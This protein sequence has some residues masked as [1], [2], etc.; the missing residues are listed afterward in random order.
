MEET[1][2]KIFQAK[3]WQLFVTAIVLS[4]LQEIA[5][6]VSD[7]LDTLLYIISIVLYVGWLLVL[8]SRFRKISSSP[9]LNY[10]VFLFV[11]CTL[12]AVIVTFRLLALFKPGILKMFDNTTVI[13]SMMAYLLT[14]LIILTSFVGK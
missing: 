10:H 7:L 14:S 4:F 13:L 6:V 12:I 8:G 3:H 1:M 5:S 11:G 2:N 9:Q